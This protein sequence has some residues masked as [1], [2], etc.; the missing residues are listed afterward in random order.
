[1]PP[2]ALRR[3][4]IDYIGF[5]GRTHRGELIVHQDVVADVTTIF[6]RLRRLRFPIAT[7]RTVDTYPGADDESSMDDN[8][9]SAFNCRRIPGTDRWAQHAYGRAVDVN[10]LL[11]PFVDRRGAFQPRTAAPYLDRART[12]PGLLHAGDPAVRAFTDQGWH[13]GGYWRTPIDYQHFEH[14]LT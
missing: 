3:V 2:A 14:P 6:A 11:N 4:D 5:D 12:D 13:W 1:M 10:P 9:T 7:M 8:N